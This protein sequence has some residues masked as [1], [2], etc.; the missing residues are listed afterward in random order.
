MVV[1][2]TCLALINP[3]S[4][5][6]PRIN[7]CQFVPFTNM[8]L[9]LP[10]WANHVENLTH[11]QT[12]VHRDS[13]CLS[14]EISIFTFS[15]P[16]LMCED[17]AFCRFTHSPSF[18]AYPTGLT[19]QQIFCLDEHKQIS[20]IILL[21]QFNVHSSY[22]KSVK[23]PPPLLFPAIFFWLLT[24]RIQ[25]ICGN[26]HCSCWLEKLQSSSRLH[27]LVIVCSPSSEAAIFLTTSQKTS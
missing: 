26:L 15:R 16:D 13:S 12:Y 14:L 5:K 20:S 27:F 10:K 17:P 19:G 21:S 24:K 22:Y 18:P 3:T 6:P 9:H 25:C 7:C 8:A 2:Q 11:I 4:Q 23:Y 1:R